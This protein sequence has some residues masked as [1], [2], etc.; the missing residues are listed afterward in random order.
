MQT[1]VSFSS[2]RSSF[3]CTESEQMVIVESCYYGG[4]APPFRTSSGFLKMS[5]DRS[6]D[7]ILKKQPSEMEVQKPISAQ[8]GIKVSGKLVMPTF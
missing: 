8:S 4:R 7:G 6:L 2:I 5:R 1:F 3:C